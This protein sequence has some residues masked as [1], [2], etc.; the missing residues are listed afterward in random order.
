M[1]DD[2]NTAAT[3]LA[4]EMVLLFI[5]GIIAV[6][7]YAIAGAVSWRRSRKAMIAEIEQHAAQDHDSGEQP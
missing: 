5:F 2:W 1:G 7:V 3:V 4:V 6:P